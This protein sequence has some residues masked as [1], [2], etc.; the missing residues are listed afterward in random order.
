MIEHDYLPVPALFH[1]PKGPAGE[2]PPGYCTKDLKVCRVEA[3]NIVL[4][5]DIVQSP[6]TTIGLILA[7]LCNRKSLQF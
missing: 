3:F 6:F 4:P 2:V 5:Q 1:L 7:C